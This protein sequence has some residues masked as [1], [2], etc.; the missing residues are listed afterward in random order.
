MSD[1]VQKGRGEA[2]EGK[3]NEREPNTVW[4]SPIFRAVSVPHLLGACSQSMQKPFFSSRPKQVFE[5]P[6]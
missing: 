4:N 5:A 2:G 3:G 1:R 6:G